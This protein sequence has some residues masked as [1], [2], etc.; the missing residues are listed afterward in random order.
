MQNGRLEGTGFI[1]VDPR[2][3]TTEEF[4]SLADAQDEAAII[5]GGAG[6]GGVGSGK[7]IIYAPV[8]IVRPNV[9]SNV[10]MSPSAL[11]DQ[12]AAMHGGQRTI[13]D[14]ADR[15]QSGS[16]IEAEH[17]PAT[18]ADTKTDNKSDASA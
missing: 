15:V 8:G 12:V 18:H 4:T 9:P 2:T 5:A 16:G 6:M 13:G 17:I 3:F 11:M 7:A 1:V 10:R 14:G